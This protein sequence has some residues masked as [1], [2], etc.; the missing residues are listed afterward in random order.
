MSFIPFIGFLAQIVL[1]Y[2]GI[3]W[4]AL[5]YLDYP[6]SEA[7][8]PMRQIRTRLREQRFLTLGFGAGQLLLSLTPV[9]NLMSVP[10]GVVA[11]TRLCQQNPL[12]ST[13]SS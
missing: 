1:L 8:T 4:C 5:E 10:A 13:A 3:Y 11:A 6:L 12:N 9:F 2:Y 7:G